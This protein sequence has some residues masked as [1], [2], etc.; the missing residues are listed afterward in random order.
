MAHFTKLFGEKLIDN[1]GTE[2]PT[3]TELEGKHV[4]IYFSAHWCPPCR[5]FTPMLAKT[6]QNLKNKNIPFEV[7]FISWDRTEDQFREYF[8]Q[9][10]WKSL[11][12]FTPNSPLR[13][14]LDKQYK[15]SGIPTLIV[16][17]KDGNTVT[18]KGR[19]AAMKDPTGS[20]FPWAPKKLHQLVESLPNI[21]GDEVQIS[22]L[23]G[24]HFGVLFGGKWIGQKFISFVQHLNTVRAKLSQSGQDFPLIFATLDKTTKDYKDVLALLPNDTLVFEFKD[25]RVEDLAE[26]LG[27]TTLPNFTVIDTDG[28]VLN[29]NGYA[30]LNADTNGDFFPWGPRAVE[31]IDLA[32]NSDINTNLCAIGI[33]PDGNAALIEKFT[34]VGQAYYDSFKKGEKDEVKFYLSNGTEA[35]TKRMVDVFK[36]RSQPCILFLALPKFLVSTDFDNFETTL[37]SVASGTHEQ[38]SSL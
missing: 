9:M 8:A 15:V 7:I 2:Y 25:P 34:T 24:K 13:K 5:Q 19:N 17:D 36:A 30:T 1:K 14:N 23:H 32:S 27:V 6:Y 37:N 16:L 11:P 29:V 18:A 28:S 38:M 3:E 10:P 35:A 12:N 22:S 33:I 21:S 20:D 31:S 4:L 26:D